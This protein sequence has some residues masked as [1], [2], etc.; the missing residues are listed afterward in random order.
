MTFLGSLIATEFSGFYLMF[1][2]EGVSFGIYDIAKSLKSRVG[3]LSS[4][5]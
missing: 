4:L 2:N 1:A 3:A 5:C